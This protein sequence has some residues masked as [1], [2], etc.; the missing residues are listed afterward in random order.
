MKLE[1][2]KYHLV[3]IIVSIL[4]IVLAF[5][6]INKSLF[7]SIEDYGII[8]DAKSM[9]GNPKQL[10]SEISKLENIRAVLESEISLLNKR[11]PASLDLINRMAKDHSVSVTGINRKSKITAKKDNIPQIEIVF[12][13]RVTNTLDLI[14]EMEYS[15]LY[16][17]ERLTVAQNP[18]D[19][20]LVNLYILLTL[21]REMSDEIR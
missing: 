6:A 3:S 13:G 15:L 5:L 11:Q 10:G 18:N 2:Y 19:E 17:A 20:N 16:T 14:N 12:S 7:S 8:R 1:Y 4:I 9:A 21:P